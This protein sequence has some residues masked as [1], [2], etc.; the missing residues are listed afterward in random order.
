[1]LLAA[2]NQLALLSGTEAGEPGGEG[3]PRQ[4]GGAGGESRRMCCFLGVA[5]EATH[6]FP[7]LLACR[8]LWRK[9]GPLPQYHPAF[10]SALLL[11]GGLQ[12]AAGILGAIAAWLQ[13][14]RRH[15]EQQAEGGGGTG[16]GGPPVGADGSRVQQQL[17]PE[18]HAAGPAF[19]GKHAAWR[20][21]YQGIQ[22]AVLH[23][24]LIS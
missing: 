20:G 17:D 24:S 15:A 2:G 13:A 16:F 6:A 3:I 19:Q 12:A 7:S 1:M 18:A 8:S 4:D 23:G 9:S 5:R 11:G 22:P 14:M 10:I 21:C